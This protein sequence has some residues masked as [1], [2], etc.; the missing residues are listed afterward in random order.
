[1]IDDDSRGITGREAVKSHRRLFK[2]ASSSLDLPTLRYRTSNE[3]R[4]G[5]RHHI[6]ER[7]ANIPQGNTRRC[8]PEIRI[9]HPADWR[10]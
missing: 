4:P 3:G 8:P 9:I 10:T 6:A 2:T 1:L 5:G 7:E